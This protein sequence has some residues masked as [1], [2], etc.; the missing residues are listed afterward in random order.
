Y[1]LNIGKVQSVTGSSTESALAPILLSRADIFS[2]INSLAIDSIENSPLNNN[3]GTIIG[4]PDEISGPEV[5]RDW[6]SKAKGD[7]LQSSVAYFL[8]RHSGA[9]RN[10]VNSSIRSAP[11]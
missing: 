2:I 8:V 10:R 7:S 1:Y 4:L 9:G 11:G 3:L 5:C 6:S